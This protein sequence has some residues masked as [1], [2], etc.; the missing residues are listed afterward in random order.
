[1]LST[2]RRRALAGLAVLGLLLG[3]QGAAARS[4]PAKPPAQKAAA[5]NERSKT[6]ETATA[7]DKAKARP[8]QRGG[9]LYAVVM[10]PGPAW[11]KGQPLRKSRSDEHWRYWQ[12]LH[13]KGLVESAGPV[14][15]DTGFALLRARNQR[16]ANAVLAADPAIRAGR[17][18]GV[19]RPYDET[20]GD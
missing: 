10:G 4:R 8:V 5:A 9:S 7:P 15:K 18:R 3:P 19:A 2:R 17:F 12:D 14:G 1:M 20:I 6:A 11:K 13:D 16:E